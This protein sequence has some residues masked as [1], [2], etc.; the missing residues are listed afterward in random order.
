MDDVKKLADCESHD[1]SPML[2]RVPS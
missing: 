1:G 2:V